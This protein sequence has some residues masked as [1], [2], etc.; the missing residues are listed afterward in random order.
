VIGSIQPTSAVWAKYTTPTFAITAGDHK[1]TI[2]GTNNFGGDN[3]AF[4]DDIK[5]Y[6]ETNSNVFGRKMNVK[7]PLIFEI[8]NR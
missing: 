5:R 7:V 8:L 1:L 2:K 4:V 6:L 3:S